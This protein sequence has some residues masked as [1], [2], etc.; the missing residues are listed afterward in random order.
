[1]RNTSFISTSAFYDRKLKSAAKYKW[2]WKLLDRFLV[3]E[4]DKGCKHILEE[5]FAQL[6]FYLSS[7][8]HILRVNIWISYLWIFL[9]KNTR[10]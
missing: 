4:D 9:D 3:F 5:C 8:A 1:M 2:F 7:I 10:L 6:L